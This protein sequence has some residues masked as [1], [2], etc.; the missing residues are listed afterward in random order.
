M[1][2]ANYTTIQLGLKLLM[3]KLS[4]KSDFSCKLYHNPTW[5]ESQNRIKISLSH[6]DTNPTRSITHPKK[7]K[8]KQYAKAIKLKLFYY[9]NII[10]RTTRFEGICLVYL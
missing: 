9:I 4:F 2:A 7:I 10:Y 3:L 1:Y 5:F 8:T 6:K